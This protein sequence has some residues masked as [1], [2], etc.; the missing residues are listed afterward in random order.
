M[1]AVAAWAAST[2]YSVGDVRKSSTNQLTGVHFK[3]TNAGTSASSEPVWSSSY[4]SITYDGGVQ[5]TAVS[6]TS[7]ELQK[8]NPS[9]IIE[10]FILELVSAIHGNQSQMT[11]RFHNGMNEVFD[12]GGTYGNV[13]FDG[14]EYIRFPIEADGFAY[15]G[16]MLPRPTIKISNILG[17]ITTI[18]S[19]SGFPGLEGAKVTRIRTLERYLDDVNFDRG[20]ILEEESASDGLV[21]EDGNLLKLEGT[22]NPHGTADSSGLFPTEVYYVDRKSTENRNVVEYELAAS[23]DIQGVRIPKRQILPGD[24]PGVGYFYS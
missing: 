6:A 14:N 22:S 20:Y 10:L 4:G 12:Q 1:A 15:D 23:F 8:P 2:A 16:K 21:L 13:V 19:I 17:T 7:S 11:Y 9:N 18:L 5:W 24:F 3:V